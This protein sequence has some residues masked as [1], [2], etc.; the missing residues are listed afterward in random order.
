MDSERDSEVPCSPISQLTGTAVVEIESD[1]EASG[2][3]K[4]RRPKEHRG[5]RADPQ[6]DIPWTINIGH[7]PSDASGVRRPRP[8]QEEATWQNL[9]TPSVRFHDLKHGQAK[10][11]YAQDDHRAELMGPFA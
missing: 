11:L 2:K 9:F 7:N 1:V 10:S 4:T 5:H 3:Y 6:S 8:Q